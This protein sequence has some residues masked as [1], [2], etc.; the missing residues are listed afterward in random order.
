MRLYDKEGRAIPAY[1]T[2]RPQFVSGVFGR[3]WDYE[4]VTIDGVEY[5]FYLD[6][7]WGKAFYFMY[8]NQYYKIPFYLYGCRPAYAECDPIQVFQ[9]GRRGTELFTIKPDVREGLEEVADKI[10]DFRK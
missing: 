8:D 6:T 2:R 9:E 4:V 3:T 1:R 5:K 10:I 7:T